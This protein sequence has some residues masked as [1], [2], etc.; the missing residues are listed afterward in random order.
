MQQLILICKK[1]L[2]ACVVP[3]HVLFGPRVSVSMVTRISR[4][5]NPAVYVEFES[6]NL[7]DETNF[8]VLVQVLIIRYA[9]KQV[10]L[11]GP[12]SLSFL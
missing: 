2:S 9:S 10:I 3:Q 7:L 6:C 11:N 8:Q 12:T 5:C 4:L 1:V